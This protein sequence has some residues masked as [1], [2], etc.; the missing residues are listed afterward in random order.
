MIG[1]QCAKVL[2]K[3]IG[4]V[5]VGVGFDISKAVILARSTARCWSTAA[6][7]ICNSNQGAEKSV[8]YSDF[9]ISYLVDSCGLTEEAATS[10]A[11]TFNLK[12]AEKPDKVLSLLRDYGFKDGL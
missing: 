11:K 10:A 1:F 5:G 2:L 8:N 6:P 7:A 9:T 3:I 12:S 4:G